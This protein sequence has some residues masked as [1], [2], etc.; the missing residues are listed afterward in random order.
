MHWPACR[1]ADGCSD[2]VHTDCRRQ[3]SA[4]RQRRLL[5]A[6]K[7]RRQS[8]STRYLRRG[9][10]PLVRYLCFA[11]AGWKQLCAAPHTTLQAP[12]RNTGCWS[13][14]GLSGAGTRRRWG[15][16]SAKARP[17]P[18]CEVAKV[19]APAAAA[20]RAEPA[21]EGACLPLCSGLLT[22]TTL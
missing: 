22:G 20:A 15:S 5:C 16:A 19:C 13:P 21:A 18:V 1:S 3:R 17:A 9:Q 12:S 2:V 7:R 8:P 4:W 14:A 10:R 6:S 11:A